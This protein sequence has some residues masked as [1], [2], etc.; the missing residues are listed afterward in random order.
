MASDETETL[1]L[2]KLTERIGSL[3]SM[4]TYY[5]MQAEKSRQQAADL[6]AEL[7]IRIKQ[8]ETF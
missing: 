6:K 5:A 8:G 2:E 4:A 7:M 1:T 3:L